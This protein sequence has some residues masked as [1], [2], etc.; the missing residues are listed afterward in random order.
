MSKVVFNNKNAVF[1]QS[2]KARVDEYFKENGLKK[3]GTW[4][5]YSK[6]IILITVCLSLY[7]VAI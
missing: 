1:F 5:L 7:L 4:K 6:T 2:L 3:T